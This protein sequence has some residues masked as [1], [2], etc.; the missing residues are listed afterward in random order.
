MAEY[1]LTGRNV[2]MTGA[3]RGLG[4]AMTEALTEAGANVVAAG[5][6]PDDFADLE[7]ACKGHKGRLHCVTADIRKSE[8]C[9]RIVE[10][11]V[12]AFGT[13]DGLVN[14]AGLTFTYIWPDGHK[15]EAWRATGE[16]PKFWEASDEVIQNVLDT[17][18]VGGD[19]LARRV[20]PLMVKKGWGRIINVTTMYRTMTKQGSSPYGPSK[21]ALECATEIWHKDL[22]GTGVTVNILNPGA[23]AAT[24]G[25][26]DEMKSRDKT[27]DNPVLIEADLMRAPVVWLMSDAT[28]NISCMRYDAKPWDPS[29]PAAEEAE[30]IG[31]KAGVLLYSMPDY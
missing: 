5:H 27:L 29:K 4:R 2:L 9:D 21:A 23:G 12:K 19:K 7:A 17:N 8:D 31:A 20:A 16:M 10:E 13:I 1:D 25:M 3:G 6:I 26:S 18:F 24:P 30:R 15:T 14:N 28:D 11:A 22:D